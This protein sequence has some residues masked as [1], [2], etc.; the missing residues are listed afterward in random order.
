MQ[1]NRQQIKWSIAIKKW[2]SNSM[3]K[4]HRSETACRNAFFTLFFLKERYL[5]RR[6]GTLVFKHW[7]S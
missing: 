7:K 6:R 1:E 3:Y 5:S 4:E 2:S